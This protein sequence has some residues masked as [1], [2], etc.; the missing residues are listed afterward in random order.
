M[1]KDI[2]VSITDGVQTIR[3]TRG[4]KKNAFSREMYAVMVDALNAADASDDIAVTVFIGLPGMFSAGN[5]MG[6]FMARAQ[7]KAEPDKPGAISASNLIRKLP[8]TKKPMI[9]AVDGL[10]IGIGVTMLLHC[11]LVYASPNAKFTA[12]FLNLGLVQEAASSLIGPQRLSY[13]RAF[14]LLVMGESWTADQAYH[15][16]L[17]NAV[18]PAAELEARALKSA[19]TL[20]SKPRAALVE[21]RRLL[22]GD[23]APIVAMMEAEGAAY[24]TL[25]KSAEAREAF[26][27]FLEKRPADFAKARAAARKV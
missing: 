12:P 9:A 5:D 27:A 4:E 22:R 21:A 19:A 20:A 8:Q 6:D 11:D 26:T 24:Q 18:V 7:G 3:F 10:A 15:A 14:E 23:T 25:L 1:S 2:N 16:G 13:A 17:I